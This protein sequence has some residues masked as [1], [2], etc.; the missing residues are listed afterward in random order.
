LEAGVVLN[1]IKPYIYAGESQDTNVT[2]IN[3]NK[4]TDRSGQRRN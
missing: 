1:N 2:E 3:A 4:L